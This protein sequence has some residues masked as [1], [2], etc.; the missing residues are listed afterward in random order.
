MP[1]DPALLALD[2]SDSDFSASQRRRSQRRRA[3]LGR[4]YAATG[5]P[6]SRENPFDRPESRLATPHVAPHAA[7]TTADDDG[8][9]NDDDDDN[10]DDYDST[11][12]APPPPPPTDAQPSTTPTTTTTTRSTAS[13]RKGI[14]SLGVTR[15]TAATDLWA[16]EPS[17]WQRM[18]VGEQRRA[19]H[20]ARIMSAAA[21]LGRR[22]P[23]PCA[24]CAAAR[25]KSVAARKTHKALRLEECWVYRDDVVGLSESVQCAACR[26]SRKGCS[27]VKDRQRVLGDAAA[28]AAAAAAHPRAE[29]AAEECVGVVAAADDDGG[30]VQEL[31]RE[32][33][34]TRRAVAILAR[35][36][37]EIRQLLGM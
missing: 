4:T 15:P 31:R 16:I 2:S 26:Y 28:A 5:R 32:L 33:K 22:A 34:E 30:E 25:R 10:E 20:V 11:P 6:T 37:A 1:I 29:A 27:F 14:S 3:R 13:K 21:D 36:L 23:H 18:S 19:W 9:D 24:Q 17:D 35:Q 8:D 12:P 7:A